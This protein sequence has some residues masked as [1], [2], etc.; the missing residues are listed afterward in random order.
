LDS[1]PTSLVID[2]L[3]FSYTFA[4]VTAI[5]IAAASLLI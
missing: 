3:L 4:F 5:M 1:L 2:I